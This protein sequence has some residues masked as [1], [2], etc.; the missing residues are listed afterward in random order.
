MLRKTDTSETVTELEE[1]AHISQKHRCKIVLHDKEIGKTTQTDEEIE[2]QRGSTGPS[3]G[4]RD[5]GSR[6]FHTHNIEGSS[7]T[8]SSFLKLFPLK[9]F[10]IV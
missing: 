1:M 8:S 4:E 7:L 5:L 6:M 9:I 2:T 3:V 10:D